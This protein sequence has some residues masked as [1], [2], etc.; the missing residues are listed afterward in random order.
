M[1]KKCE[2]CYGTGTIEGAF[3]ACPDGKWKKLQ[4]QI[5]E[6]AAAVEAEE[7]M[8][9]AAAEAKQKAM[10][11]KSSNAQQSSKA[12]LF[13]EGDWVQ[14][15]DQSTKRGIR[16]KEEYIGKHG[17]VVM[18]DIKDETA[19][20]INPHN[21]DPYGKPVGDWFSVDQLDQVPQPRGIDEVDECMI[22][23]ALST[24]D[25]EWFN[26]LSSKIVKGW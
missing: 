15:N 8:K 22:N 3:C 14:F 18:V 12:F 21:I 13:G 16:I 26:E 20:V 24:N 7:R 10:V 1:A 5:E 11:A 23:L 17:F 25:V 19:Y 4:K 2:I 9:K 6:K